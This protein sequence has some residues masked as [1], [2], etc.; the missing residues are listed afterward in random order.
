MAEVF[1]I[2]G[3]LGASKTGP[4]A[5]LQQAL[6]ILAQTVGDPSV[7]TGV[8]G[9]IG[10]NTV[11]AL[12]SAFS[13]YGG[14]NRTDWTVA[15]ARKSAASLASIVQSVVRQRGGTIPKPRAKKAG[16]ASAADRAAAQAAMAPGSFLDTHPNLVWWGLGG[17]GIVIV[18]GFMA[19]HRRRAAQQ[20]R[21]PASA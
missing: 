13:Q 6:N 3:A 18:L 9:V 21:V 8:D 14:S 11:K 10:P 7:K 4:A 1:T 17:A 20:A 19:Q 2:S 12:N 16:G 15:D 5:E